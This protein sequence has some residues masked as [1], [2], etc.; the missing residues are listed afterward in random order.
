LTE[1]DTII[2]AQW[3]QTVVSEWVAYGIGDPQSR[4]VMTGAA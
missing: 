4:L 3:N 2:D 1:S